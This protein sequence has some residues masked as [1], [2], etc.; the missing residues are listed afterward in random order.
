MGMRTHELSRRVAVVVVGIPLVLAAL[1]MGRWWFGVVLA[2]VAMIATAELFG[3]VDARGGRP[4]RVIG[5]AASGAI[6][7]L[8]TAEPTPA[9]AGAYILAVL[10]AL[11]LIT[12]TASAWLRWPAGEPQD[13]VAVTLLGA[14]YVGGT[15]S[16]AVFLRNLPATF[17]PAVDASSWSEMRFVLLPLVSVW[18]GDS[19]AFFA[20]HAWGRRKLF[21]EVSPG[22]TVV[23]GVAGLIGSTV[24]GMVVAVLTLSSLPG[25]G[26][27]LS[28]GALVGA[29]I[30][31]AAPLGDAAESVLKREAGVKDSGSLL[32]GHGGVLD[33]I[34]S[35]LFAFPVTY[36]VLA[37]LGRMG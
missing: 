33:R 34:D 11:V 18:V 12:L 7:L 23:G 21:P 24:A 32:P 13:A 15:L 22:K 20:G 27:S 14:V 35:L 16:F 4:Y 17:A 9:G 30:G 10:V 3:L 26:V 1:Y 31:V 28:T 19:A 5:M 8:A 25:A 29:V 2:G 6:V 37:L 36:G